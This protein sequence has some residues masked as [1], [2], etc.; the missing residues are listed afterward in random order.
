MKTVVERAMKRVQRT[1]VKLLKNTV[2]RI[3]HSK[4]F[5]S[6]RTRTLQRN[7]SQQK[8]R[9]EKGFHSGQ[10]IQY[11]GKQSSISIMYRVGRV[12]DRLGLR[13]WMV[14][15]VSMMYWPDGVGGSSSF[16]GKGSVVIMLSFS[17]SILLSK[18]VLEIEISVQHSG[19]RSHYCLLGKRWDVT[20][21]CSSRQRCVTV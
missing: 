11:S 6:T 12:A 15:S 7:L 1:S 3:N 16:S 20:Q 19:Q 17:T 18:N 2:A 14:S 8:C 10:S 4:Y 5:F 9:G 21:R 13:S